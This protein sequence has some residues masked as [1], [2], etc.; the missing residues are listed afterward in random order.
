M[1]RL[2]WVAAL[3]CCSSA[4]LQ[5]PGQ[6]SPVTPGLNKYVYKKSTLRDTLHAPSIT[7]N[8]INVAPAEPLCGPGLE[9]VATADC[10][11]Y[12][13]AQAQLASLPRRD[14][15]R[16]RLIARL[17]CCGNTDRVSPSPSVSVSRSTVCSQARRRVCC[18]RAVLP[19]VS[20]PS[21]LQLEECGRQQT[22]RANPHGIIVSANHAQPYV[23]MR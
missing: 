20:P 13:R 5:F 21:S 14:P 2:V 12:Q 9:C 11:S 17:R 7:G 22:S 6:P 8:S 16:T 4:Q 1:M 18:A 15:A 10:P 23:Q 19:P 3:L